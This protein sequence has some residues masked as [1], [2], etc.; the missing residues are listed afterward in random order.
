MKNFLTIVLLALWC[1]SAFAQQDTT[2]IFKKF[3]EQMDEAD[4]QGLFGDF[5]EA[6]KLYDKAIATAKSVNNGYNT[7]RYEWSCGSCSRT[8][9]A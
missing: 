2:A 7:S 3:Q 9:G 5:D 6:I 1:S 4:Y 8:R